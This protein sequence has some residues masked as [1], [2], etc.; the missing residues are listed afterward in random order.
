MT[1]LGLGGS[2]FGNLYREMSDVV[3]E[4]T[5]ATAWESGIR[6]VD[7]AP[8]YGLG[9]SE[10]RLGRLL[11][12]HRREDYV[13][14]TK[15]GRRLVPNTDHAGEL[16]DEGFAVPARSRRVWDFSRD[17]VRRCLEESLHRLGLDRVD[18]VYLHDPEGHWEQA[19]RQGLPA[20]QELRDEGMVSAIGAGMNLAGHLAELIRRFDLDLVMCAGRYTL[21]EQADDLMTAA[22]EH[23]VGVVVAGVYNSGL[24]ARPRPG[25]EPRYD[26]RP[27]PRPLVERVQA[28]ADVC[29]RHGVQLPDAALA[30]PFRHPAVVSVVVGASGPQQVRQAVDRLA[31]DIPP[32]LWSD[33]AGAGLISEAST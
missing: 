7:T 25:P 5:F 17:G 24:L 6:Y 18:V 13:L 23:G 21:L 26:Y 32:A 27:A 28:I 29:D 19:L 10:S 31:V 20:L 8:H 30:F 3:A 33:L 1:R 14:S 12:Q 4:Q 15:V 16:D 22:L 11:R 9:L 2:Q